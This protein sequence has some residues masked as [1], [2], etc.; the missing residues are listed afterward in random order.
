M[1]HKP[2]QSKL[3]ATTIPRV[4]IG[5]SLPLLFVKEK[6]QNK[7]AA[8]LIANLSSLVLDFVVRQKLGGSTDGARLLLHC[9]SSGL[10]EE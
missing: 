7:Y 5:N 4:G 9:E 6:F 3:I 2:R 10:G 8:F 1:I